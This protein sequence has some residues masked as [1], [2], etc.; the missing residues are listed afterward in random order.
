LKRPVCQTNQG[1]F[2]NLKKD[3]RYLKEETPNIGRIRNDFK[4][5]D[6]D[7]DEEVEEE[8]EDENDND[9]ENDNNEN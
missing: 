9:N 8:V 1:H 4:G 5:G 3:I 7:E 6:D 2:K